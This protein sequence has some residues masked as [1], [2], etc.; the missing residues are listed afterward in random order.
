MARMMSRPSKTVDPTVQHRKRVYRT[1]VPEW[2]QKVL[3]LW[4]FLL[5]L[6]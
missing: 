5:Y 2:G 4:H 3:N 6:P 1:K